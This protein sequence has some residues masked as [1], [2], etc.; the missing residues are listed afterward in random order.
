M[1]EGGDI[2]AFQLKQQSDNL[3]TRLRDLAP[4]MNSEDTFIGTVCSEVE[5]TLRIESCILLK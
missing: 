2:A 5:A 1:A 3:S 4:A